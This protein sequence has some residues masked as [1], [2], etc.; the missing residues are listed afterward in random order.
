MIVNGGNAKEETSLGTPSS[1][2]YRAKVFIQEVVDGSSSGSHSDQEAV[3]QHVKK[4]NE[5]ADFE[6]GVLSK[7]PEGN[8]VFSILAH[9]ILLKLFV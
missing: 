4:L 7:T 9:A 3:V 2:K 5:V 1:R 8:I 6:E